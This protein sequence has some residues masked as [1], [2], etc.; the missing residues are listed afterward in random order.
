MIMQPVES[1]ALNIRKTQ[2]LTELEKLL[3]DQELIKRI[4]EMAGEGFSMTSL[5]RKAIGSPSIDP[6]TAKLLRKEIET[7]QPQCLRLFDELIKTCNELAKVDNP[8][9]VY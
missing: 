6:I 4:R 2:I 9:I 8:L 1:G 3:K 7:A 5:L